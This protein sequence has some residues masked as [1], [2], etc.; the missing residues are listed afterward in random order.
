MMNELE[1]ANNVIVKALADFQVVWFNINKRYNKLRWI[2]F[3]VSL[4]YL[5]DIIFAAY[6]IEFPMI[7][8]KISH[9]T[10]LMHVVTTALIFYAT[11]YYANDYASE[12]LLVAVFVLGLSIRFYMVFVAIVLAYVCYKYMERR[13]FKQLKKYANMNV[14]QIIEDMRQKQKAKRRGGKPVVDITIRE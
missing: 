10:V 1:K 5:I 12:A 9:V 3:I 6:I 4:Y 11:Y 2:P 8:M 13:R 14:N 7:F